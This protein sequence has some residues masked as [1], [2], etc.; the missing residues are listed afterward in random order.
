MGN[1]LPSE[2]AGP[3][4][5]VQSPVRPLKGKGKGEGEEDAGDVSMA[6]TGDEVNK[7]VKSA[8]EKYTQDPA[9]L[10]AWKD[11]AAQTH[12]S[13]VIILSEYD[14]G[15]GLLQESH[16]SRAHIPSPWAMGTHQLPVPPSRH[17]TVKCTKWLRRDPQCQLHSSSTPP[18]TRPPTSERGRHKQPRKQGER[19]N[20]A[21]CKVPS[22]SDTDIDFNPKRGPSPYQ[23]R[24][25][26]A[27]PFTGHFC[28]ILDTPHGLQSLHPGTKRSNT[29]RLGCEQRR[30]GLILDASLAGAP[31]LHLSDHRQSVPPAQLNTI[32]L[33]VPSNEEALNLCETSSGTGYTIAA[34][35]VLFRP[36]KD[37]GL[38]SQKICHLSRCMD[39][40]NKAEQRHTSVKLAI[41][42]AKVHI[43]QVCLA[44]DDGQA[45]SLLLSSAFDQQPAVLAPL[46]TEHLHAILDTHRSLQSRQL[47]A[48]SSKAPNGL[49]V[50]GGHRKGLILDASLA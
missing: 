14:H 6:E 9:Q 41:M 33:A 36:N 32:S 23:P 8:K 37:G 35:N 25:A 22:P 47:A 2:V 26:L 48:R 12:N 18:P 34:Q 21:E 4:S 20:T 24:P 50:N 28:V 17:K 16:R 19:V 5:E 49:G 13:E 30:E 15:H 43:I 42:E 1:L 39:M 27:P 10:K 29:R 7:E 3:Y 46:F 31:L 11:L 44:E 38:H 45:S 40:Q